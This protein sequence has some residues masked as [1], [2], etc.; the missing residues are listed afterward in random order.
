MVAVLFGVLL[1]LSPE[2][3]KEAILKE[4]RKFMR[5]EVF[6][7][8]KIQ[9]AIDTTAVGGLNYGAVETIRKQVE[10][11]GKYE[12]GCFPS[13]TSVANSARL[14]EKHAAMAH[15]IGF[16]EVETEIGLSYV[17]DFA[18]YLRLLVNAHGMT[19]IAKT[20]SG[21][22]P[23][24]IAVTLDGAALTHELGHVSGGLKN[25]DPRC[26]HPIT[27]M[28]IAHFQSR[29]EAFI[30]QLTF[31]RDYKAMYDVCFKEFFEFFSGEVVC[32]ATEDQ[33]ELS[34]FVVVSPQDMASHWKTTGLGGSSSTYFCVCCTCK[35]AD[36]MLFKTGADMC[37]D[38]KDCS[39]EGVERCYCRTVTDG[40]H[41]QETSKLCRGG[42]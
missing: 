23:M 5:R 25:V 12:R 7:P 26:L 39:R 20:G 8:W 14:L 38:C 2:T 35:S 24:M 37:G 16:E 40:Q 27:G 17:F 3:F 1:A 6:E 19:D 42:P 30:L 22:K 36:K 11:L 29:D 41:L 28:P 10:G 13:R 31:G 21:R 32:P 33:P 18:T 15:G 34:N 4:S 9:R